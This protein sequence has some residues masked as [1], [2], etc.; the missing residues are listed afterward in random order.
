MEHLGN[1]YCKSALF[2]PHFVP[3]CLANN[4]HVW[5][6]R[7]FSPNKWLHEL[8]MDLSMVE[9]LI[10]AI[11][12]NCDNG[13]L[14]IKMNSSKDNVKS[15]KHVKGRLKIVRNLRSS[16]VIDLDYILTIENLA[17]RFTK[18]SFMICDWQHIQR[19]GLQTH[20]VS[21]SMAEH[22]ICDRRSHE[23]GQWNKS[24]LAERRV[25]E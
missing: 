2:L 17:D 16:R 23:L 9:K 3:L 22:V 20:L 14:I 5:D 18:G 7:L 15:S 21:H 25:F 6:F 13:T 24:W 10:P 19:I 8:M 12:M 11:L 1:C 4:L